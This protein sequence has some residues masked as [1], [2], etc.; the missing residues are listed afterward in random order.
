MTV[1]LAVFFFI[2]SVTYM[3][4]TT[5]SSTELRS[6]SI[7]NVERT[8]RSSS[9][10]RVEERTQLLLHSSDEHAVEGTERVVSPSE[11]LERTELDTISTENVAER[12]S[13]ERNSSA[14]VV[15]SWP[16]SDMI[17]ALLKEATLPSSIHT[18]QGNI[19]RL[20]VRRMRITRTLPT[21]LPIAYWP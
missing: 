14:V 6:S 5:S 20:I 7:P 13:T 4:R 8:E 9:E 11:N 18:K 10:H 17:D 21:I 15:S 2:V 3:T 16:P 12:G 19:P 1:V